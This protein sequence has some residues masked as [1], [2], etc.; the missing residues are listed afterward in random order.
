MRS[1][2]LLHNCFGVFITQCMDMVQVQESSVECCCP[3]CFNIVYITQYMD[4]VQVQAQL[5]RQGLEVVCGIMSSNSPNPLTA[6][7]AASHS[8]VSALGRMP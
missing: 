8:Q 7:L 2:V 5:Q 3:C 6:T 1:G 4:M